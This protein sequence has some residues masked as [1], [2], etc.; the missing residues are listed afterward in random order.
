MSRNSLHS[1]N[2]LVARIDAAFFKL[3][4]KIAGVK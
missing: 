1:L 4:L 3:I 2:A